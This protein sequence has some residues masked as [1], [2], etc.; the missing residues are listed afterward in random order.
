MGEMRSGSHLDVRSIV[1]G[2]FLFALTVFGPVAA[3][4]AELFIRGTTVNLRAGP[5]TEFAVLARMPRGTEVDPVGRLGSWTYVETRAGL[6]GYIRSDLLSSSRPAAVVEPW[7]PRRSERTTRRSEART[8]R[9]APHPRYG[10]GSIQSAIRASIA[11]YP[12][13]C[14]CPYSYDRAGRRC[15]GRSAWSRRGGYAPLCYPS[16]VR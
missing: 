9:P 13:N 10:G 15:G 16:D 2:A 8:T 6:T 3:S 7:R 11:A 1:L 14:P 5:G 12:G 4:A